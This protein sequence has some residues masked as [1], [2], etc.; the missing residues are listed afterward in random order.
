[1]GN[2][3]GTDHSR[4]LGVDERIILKW[5]LKELSMKGWARFDWLGTEFNSQDFKLSN[6]LQNLIL[7]Y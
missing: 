3:K 1:L 5:I 7:T 4:N 2:L 6:K